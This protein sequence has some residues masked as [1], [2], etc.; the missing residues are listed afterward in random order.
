MNYLGIDLTNKKVKVIAKKFLP[1]F[2]EMIKGGFLCEDGFGCHPNTNGESIYG[3]WIATGEP[4]K[5]GGR[6]VESLIN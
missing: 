4:D 1:E 6:D 5:I 2:Q 3:K